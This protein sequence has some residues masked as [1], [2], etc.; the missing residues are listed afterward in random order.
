MQQFCFW[1]LIVWL[2]LQLH[3]LSLAKLI[4]EKCNIS[5]GKP[6]D[7]NYISELQEELILQK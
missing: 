2:H 5:W 1:E 7:Y 6:S 3:F 4:L